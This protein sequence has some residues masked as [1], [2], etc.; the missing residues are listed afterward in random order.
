MMVFYHFVTFRV[1]FNSDAAGVNLII[2]EMINQQSLYPDTLKYNFEMG[3]IMEDWLLL[4][5]A[6]LMGN[7]YHVHAI[8]ALIVSILIAFAISFCLYQGGLK[9]IFI[10]F[11]LIFYFSTLGGVN[12]YTVFGEFSYGYFVFYAAMIL[13]LVFGIMNQPEKNLKEIAGD[14]KS[15]WRIIVYVILL[16]LFMFVFFGTGMRMLVNLSLPLIVAII[17][18]CLVDREYFRVNKTKIMILIIL[19]V[20]AYLFSQSIYPLLRMSLSGYQS[21]SVKTYMDYGDF[22]SF[23]DRNLTS[24]KMFLDGLMLRN[25]NDAE[26]FSLAMAD[27]LVKVISIGV[28]GYALIRIKFLKNMNLK[29]VILFFFASLSANILACATANTI[30]QLTARYFAIQYILLTIALAC[31]LSEFFE[32]SK[33]FKKHWAFIIVISAIPLVYNAYVNFAEPGFRLRYNEKTQLEFVINKNRYEPLVDFLI[34]KNI[35]RAYAHYWESQVLTVLSNFRVI[36]SPIVLDKIPEPAPIGLKNWYDP[37]LSAK[38]SALILRDKLD[39][40]RKSKVDMILGKEIERY[41]VAGFDIYVYEG[42]FARIW[43]KEGAEF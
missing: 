14:P 4:P 37:K 22:S 38:R 16:F 3:L 28:V 39:V 9:K 12:T 17:C 18:L 27:K 20:L 26:V 32:R 31:C 2:N 13:G 8:G 6:L 30:L 23:I 24:I 21:G 42:N 1:H 15:S 41:R 7:G 35:D 11:G 10:I 34:K 36:V 33:N 25:L 19:P 40:E 43:S 5:V 29:L